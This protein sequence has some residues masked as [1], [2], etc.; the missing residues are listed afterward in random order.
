MMFNHK[1][2][3]T[4]TGEEIIVPFSEKETNEMLAKIAETEKMLSDDQ[5]KKLEAEQKRAA[6]LNKLGITEEE[7]KSLLS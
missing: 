6:I 2:V 4:E 1:I 3:N 5:A 7:A